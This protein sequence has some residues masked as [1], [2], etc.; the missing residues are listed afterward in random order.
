M[1]MFPHRGMEKIS[2]TRSQQLVLIS[3]IVFIRRILSIGMEGLPGY[4]ETTTTQTDNTPLI[5]RIPALAGSKCSIREQNPTVQCVVMDN[6]G[7]PDR[8]TRL[9]SCSDGD[10]DFRFPHL[11]RSYLFH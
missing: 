9:A 11:S 2:K 5:G 7:Q 3:L 6:T 1:G 8:N 10:T 4:S